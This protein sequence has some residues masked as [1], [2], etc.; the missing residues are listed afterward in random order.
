VLPDTDQKVS[1][2]HLRGALPYG[3]TI[4]NEYTAGVSLILGPEFKSP[5]CQ[6]KKKP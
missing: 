4:I 5:Y 3:G 6:K 2:D 1:V